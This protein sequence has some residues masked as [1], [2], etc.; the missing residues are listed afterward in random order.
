MPFFGRDDESLNFA[1]KMSPHIWERAQDDALVPL[2]IIPFSSS[3]A[4]CPAHNLVP[5]LACLVAE[6]VLAE[7]ELSLIAPRLDRQRLP[8][9]LDH[10]EIRLG[11]IG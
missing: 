11:T 3:P 5:L 10:L 1:P 7:R 8:G 2:G 6:A 9:T 4:I